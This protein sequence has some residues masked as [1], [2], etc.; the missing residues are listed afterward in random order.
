MGQTQ[1]RTAAEHF[2]NNGSADAYES[3]LYARLN[4]LLRKHGLDDF[5][6]AQCAGFYAETIG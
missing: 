1:R 5:P 3:P 2:G 4:R 6:E